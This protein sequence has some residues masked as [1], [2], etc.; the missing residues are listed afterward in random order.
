MA[1]GNAYVVGRLAEKAGKKKYGPSGFFDRVE[2]PCVHHQRSPILDSAVRPV[3]SQVPFADGTAERCA[4]TRRSVATLQRWPPPSVRFF[5]SL[6]YPRVLGEDRYQRLSVAEVTKE[7]ADEAAQID[8]GPDGSRRAAPPLAR[9]V[10]VALDGNGEC[11]QRCVLPAPSSLAWILT[12][13]LVPIRSPRAPPKDRHW[14]LVVRICFSL[15]RTAHF[16]SRS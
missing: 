6:P 9:N 13:N 12:V 16:Y 15:L 2:P 1:R 10:V 3:S 4:P 5:P 11:E 8:A 7:D 14:V